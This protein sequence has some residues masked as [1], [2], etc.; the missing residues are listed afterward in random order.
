MLGSSREPLLCSREKEREE[1]ANVR[2]RRRERSVG[3]ERSV[4]PRVVRVV[5][6]HRARRAASHERRLDLPSG[7]H[8]HD[9]LA[10]AS[11]GEEN[12]LARQ[13]AVIEALAAA[14][15]RSRAALDRNQKRAIVE[16]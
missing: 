4:R 2:R 7:I 9:R 8:E 3:Q 13:L 1:I 12:A 5:A 6:V 14:R 11:I 16:S 15:T 10:V